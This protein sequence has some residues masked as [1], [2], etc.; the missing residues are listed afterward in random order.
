[1][2]AAH[3][4]FTVTYVVGSS[5]SAD[6]PQDWQ[7]ETGWIDEEKLARLAFPPSPGTVLWLCGV[8]AMYTSLAGSRMKPLREGT[9]IHSLGYTEEMLWRS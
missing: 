2:A 1:M 5:A 4:R 8:D 9:P 6:T 3:P 7:G